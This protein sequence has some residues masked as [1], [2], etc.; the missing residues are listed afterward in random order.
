MDLLL[1][2]IAL[3]PNRWTPEKIPYYTLDRLLPHIAGTD[4]KALEVWQHHVSQASESDVQWYRKLADDLGLTLSILGLYPR[5]HLEGE[6]GQQE[7]DDIQHLLDVAGILGAELIKIFPGSLGTE[8]VTDAEYDRS[9][10]FMQEMARRAAAADL[11][12]TC[13]THAN[14]LCDTR[15]A[16][17][18]FLRD[19][20]AENLKVCYQPYDFTDTARAIVDYEALAEHVI[21]VHYQGRKHG[22]MVLLQHADLDY[23]AITDVLMTHGF[24]GSLCIEF[25]KDCVVPTPADFDLMQVLNNARRDYSFVRQAVARHSMVLS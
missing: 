3:D 9:M 23:E 21:H 14:T 6:A 22:E 1:N 11:T 24:D 19:V 10:A 18:R 25:V 20:N 2:T 4:F 7:M 12:I 16:C 5:L 13:E 8:G 17:L 15:E